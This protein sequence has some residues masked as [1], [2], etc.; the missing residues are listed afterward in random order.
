MSNTNPPKFLGQ[1]SFLCEQ[2]SSPCVFAHVLMWQAPFLLS[3][4]A[5]PSFSPTLESATAQYVEPNSL[6]RFSLPD[7]HMEL[8]YS[9]QHIATLHVQALRESPAWCVT[10]KDP[11]CG[12]VSLLSV[13]VDSPVWAS[14]LSGGIVSLDIA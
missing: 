1:V 10:L 6:E 9:H 3:G 7:D 4:N 12:V 11:Q 14:Y 5:T 13:L 2:N 8:Y